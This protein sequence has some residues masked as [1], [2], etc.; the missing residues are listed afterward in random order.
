MC[1]CGYDGTCNCR[2]MRLFYALIGV[3]VGILVVKTLR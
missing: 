2:N 1:K 3:L